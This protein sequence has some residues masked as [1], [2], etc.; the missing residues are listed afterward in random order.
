M[1]TVDISKYEENRF[2]TAVA[3][4]NFDGIHIGHQQL[5]KTMVKKSEELSLKNS[6]LLF[7]NHTKTVIDHNRPKVITNNDQKL[8]IAKDLGVNLIYTMD[9]NEEVMKLSGEEFV[10]NILIDRIRAKLLVVGFDYRFGYKASGNAD[11]LKELGNKLNFQVEVVRPVYENNQIVSSTTIRNLISQG[12]IRQANNMLGRNYTLIG[13]VISGKNRGNKLGFPTANIDP[14][15]NYVLPETGVY[16]TNTIVDGCK[17][18]SVTNIGYNPTFNEDVLKIESHILDFSDNIY[19][20][21]LE[22]E[23]IDYIREDIKFTNKDELIYQI[24]KD[25]E[26]VKKTY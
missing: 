23:F 12:H 9:F 7:K 11:Y 17:Y 15:D 13:T 24:N 19:G 3:L 8:K 6:L 26:L 20:K 21:K 2:N 5:I 4:G 18:L 16:K 1:E 14:I 25:I 22:I 10:K